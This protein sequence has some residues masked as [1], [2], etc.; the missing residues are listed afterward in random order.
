MI[1]IGIIRFLIL[2]R[3]ENN[4]LSEHNPILLDGSDQNGRKKKLFRFEK[5]WLSNPSFKD[6]IQSACERF[7]VQ[8]SAA[9][10]I[11]K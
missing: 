7:Q 11:M 6:M 4:Q 1:I 10:R 9:A 8:G 3:E 2:V 5:V